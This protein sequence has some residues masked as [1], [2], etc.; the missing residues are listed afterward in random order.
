MRNYTNITSPSLGDIFLALSIEE[1]QEFTEKDVD[2]GMVLNRIMCPTLYHA[3]D[4][5]LRD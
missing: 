1:E 4:Y 2:V 3:V 5:V